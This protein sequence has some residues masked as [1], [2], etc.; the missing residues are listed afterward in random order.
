M[1]RSNT[2]VD[3][4]KRSLVDLHHAQPLLEHQTHLRLWL[5]P[6]DQGLTPLWDPTP[7]HEPKCDIHCRRHSVSHVCSQDRRDQPILEVL[8]RL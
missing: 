4:S 1:C 6:A 7:Q 3:N 2:Y 8:L 5:C